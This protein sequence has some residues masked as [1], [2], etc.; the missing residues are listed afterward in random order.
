MCASYREEPGLDALAAEDFER[1]RLDPLLAS[2]QWRS[3]TVAPKSDYL[4]SIFL[5]EFLQVIV[6]YYPL[7]FIFKTMAWFNIA[8]L[9]LVC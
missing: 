6:I 7:F 1:G 8:K 2:L 3:L 4:P 9:K 5:P